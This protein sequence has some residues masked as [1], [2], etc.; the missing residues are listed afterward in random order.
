MNERSQTLTE[1][2]KETLRLLL[3]GHDAKSAAS[4]L[5]LSV[6]TVNERLREARRKLGV[7]SSRE[8]ARALARA[9]DPNFLGDKQFGVAGTAAPGPEHRPSD[10]RRRLGWPLVWLSGGMVMMLAMVAAVAMTMAPHG[11]GQAKPAKTPVAYAAADP[12][13]DKAGADFAQA[14]AKLLDDQRWSES[15]KTSG[16]FF[17]SQIDEARWT[18]T[19]RTLRQSLGAVGSRSVKSVSSARSLPGVP[20]GDYKII[21]FA[22]AFANKPAGIETVVLAKEGGD[23]KIYGYFIR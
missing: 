11:D 17:Q 2:E 12:A 21:Q 8:A 10:Q 1:R 22:T 4:A 14:W 13:S 20:D 18:E 5:G 9:E 6:H 15:W 16:A 7:G 23:W 19:A 3:A